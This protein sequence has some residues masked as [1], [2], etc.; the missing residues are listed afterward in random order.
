MLF[1]TGQD[2]E[3]Q[4]ASCLQTTQRTTRCQFLTE[5]QQSVFAY[6]QHREQQ[7]ASSL[8]DMADNKKMQVAYT[9]HREQRDASS[10]Q[11]GNSP[12]FCL[13]T[14]QRTMRC[15]FFTRQDRDQQDASCLQTT[16]RTTRCQFLTGQDK[17]QQNA[18]WLQTTQRTTRCQ[19][20]TERQQS[21][22][23]YRQHREQ[24]RC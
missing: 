12:F 17:E 3:Q 10:L 23:A 9:Q 1:L 24:P 19:I 20:L 13:Q 8:Q 6:K 2:I 5:R 14:T 18:S 22:L 7:D 4:N 11:R 16:Y 15:W 21:V